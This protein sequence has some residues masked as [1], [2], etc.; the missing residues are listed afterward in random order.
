MQDRS[1]YRSLRAACK[2]TGTLRRLDYTWSYQHGHNPHL[3]LLLFTGQPEVDAA[4]VQGQ[5]AEAWAQATAA[6]GRVADLA[7]GCRV[8]QVDPA[9]EDRAAVAAYLT[10]ASRRKKVD[11]DG[12]HLAA[13][14]LL[15]C[16]AQTGQLDGPEARAWCEYARAF[17]G[18]HPFRATP[19]LLQPQGEPQREQGED[20]LLLPSWHRLT[21]P[22][23]RQAEVLCRAGDLA[24]LHVLASL[25]E[26]DEQPEAFSYEV[27]GDFAGGAGDAGG[28]GEVCNGGMQR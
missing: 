21:R 1:L 2:I 22:Q 5:L 4:A 17:K 9:P 26:Q 28:S 18:Q 12:L 11:R 15:R 20:I 27:Y 13:H 25:S 3:H 19:A 14:G 10:N 23:R 6:H 24:A 7:N 16:V 8:R